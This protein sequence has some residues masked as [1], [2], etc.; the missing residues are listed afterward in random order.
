MEPGLAQISTFNLAGRRG[1][2]QYV[3][4]TISPDLALLQETKAQHWPAPFMAAQ[5]TEGR[6]RLGGTGIWASAA[7]IEPITIPRPPRH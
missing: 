5:Q 2:Q 3:Q 1:G 7:E 6:A 4:H